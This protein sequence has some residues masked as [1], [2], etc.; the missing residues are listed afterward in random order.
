MPDMYE[1]H[2]GEELL[3][4]QPIT[5]DLKEKILPPIETLKGNKHE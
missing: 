2:T 5:L 3:Q 4:F 1:T